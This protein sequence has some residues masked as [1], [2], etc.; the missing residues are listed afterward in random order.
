M[1]SV[2]IADHAS[3]GTTVCVK[4]MSEH[5]LADA[6]AVARFNDEAQAAARIRSPHVV[7]VFDH[8]V[9]DGIPY[10]VMELLEGE[11]LRTRLARKVR[12]DPA[13]TLCIARQVA[14]A[15]DKAH[16]SGVIHR[17]IK[18]AN[19]FLLDVGGETFVK[20]LDFGIAKLA[21]DPLRTSPVEAA[22]RT[23]SAA[24]FGTPH[25]MSPEQAESAG[26]V[27]KSADLWSLAVV[28]YQ[29][30]T[31][32]LPFDAPTL[33]GL[34]TRI[35]DANFERA[36][37]LRPELPKAVD[38][39]F[40]RALARDEAARFSSATAMAQGFA[41]ALETTMLS[42]VIP[43]GAEA[44]TRAPRRSHARTAIGVLAVAALAV[45]TAVYVTSRGEA[46]TTAAAHQHT[47]PVVAAAGVP[48]DTGAPIAAL[49]VESVAPPTAT[50][51]APAPIARA[52]RERSAGAAAVPVSTASAPPRPSRTAVRVT[53]AVS[54]DLYEPSA[55]RAAFERLDGA[56]TA[57]LDKVDPRR[58]RPAYFDVFAVQVAA[59]G[60]VTSVDH[61][62]S[63][64]GDAAMDAC[65]VAVLS[66]AALGPTATGKPGVVEIGYTAGAGF[67][68]ASDKADLESG[69]APR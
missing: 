51:P 60:R 59:D 11:D 29:C 38:A 20:L 57:C 45:S 15:L 13:E 5:G 66:G 19:V 56:L 9:T 35:H 41:A 37:T 69:T 1:G 33:F 6:K 44:R 8:G 32:A 27:T 10:I 30:V 4:L 63:G 34:C 12:L 65:A 61:K 50:P 43:I 46:G 67:E 24:I 52:S 31:G 54:N 39:W 48:E 22:A 64:S 26:A 62:G 49:P 18:P 17:D 23:E 40:A 3:L 58:T 47:E 28:V 25:Y 53:M 42:E 14:T 7:Q 2:W 16:A 68:R 55:M 21:L 36:T